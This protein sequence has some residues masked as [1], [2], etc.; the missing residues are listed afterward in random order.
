MT[1][2]HIAI[3]LTSLFV[4]IGSF[5]MPDLAHA[6]ST[7]TARD[8]PV[9]LREDLPKQAQESLVLIR[10]GG[11]F[12][13]SKDNS[14]FGNREGALPKQRRGYYHEFTVKT[15]KS[16]DRGARR[17]VCGGEIRDRANSDCFYTDDHYASFK[18]IKE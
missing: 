6:K 12:P 2:R 13:Y 10:K 9:I 3:S 7:P 8:F 1:H 14:T 5:L 11:P 17:I 18:R 16:R 4:T 15:P